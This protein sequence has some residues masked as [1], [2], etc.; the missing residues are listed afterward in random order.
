MYLAI[1]D[2]GICDSFQLLIASAQLYFRYCWGPKSTSSNVD[3]EQKFKIA[4]LGP[5][6]YA[7]KR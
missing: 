6:Q 4:D 1:S 7:N 5:L 3:Q 2:G